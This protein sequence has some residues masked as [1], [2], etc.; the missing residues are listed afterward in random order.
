MALAGGYNDLNVVF[1][2]TRRVAKTRDK[3]M[4]AVTNFKDELANILSEAIPQDPNKG[5]LT[6]Y[7]LHLRQ[8]YD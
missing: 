8:K 6:A 3:C 4:M 5:K 1:S 7:I 2:D